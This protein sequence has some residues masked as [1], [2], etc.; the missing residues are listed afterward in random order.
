MTNIEFVKL[1]NNILKNIKISDEEIDKIL[2]ENSE[3][4]ISFKDKI[5]KTLEKNILMIQPQHIARIIG[6]HCKRESIKKNVKKKK[7]NMEKI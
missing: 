4:K 7:R 3:D 1:L 5:T 2:I 6:K